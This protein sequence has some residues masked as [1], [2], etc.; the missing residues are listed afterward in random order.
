MRPPLVRDEL[1]KDV[2]EILAKRVG[3]RC[4]NPNCRRPTSGPQENRHKMINIG[5]AAHISAAAPGGPRFDATMAPEERSGIENA[6]WLCQNCAKLID[7]DP[8]RYTADLLEQW[9]RVSEEA[10]LLA[11]ESLPFDASSLFK[12]QHKGLT[13]GFAQI[14]SAEFALAMIAGVDRVRFTV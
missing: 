9:R 11:V 13:L 12:K 8:V 6:I 14:T 2:K 3:S 5:V 1:A 10:A 7:N 4:S